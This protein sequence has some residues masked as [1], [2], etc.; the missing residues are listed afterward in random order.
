MTQVGRSIRRL[1]DPRLVTG[2]GHFVDDLDRAG[3]VHA[4]FVRASVAHAVLRGVEVSDALALDGVRAVISATDVDLPRIPLRVSPMVEGLEAYL[5]P[6]LATGR[7]RYVGEPIA[8]VVADDPYAAEDA[9]ELVEVDFEVLPCNLDPERS[10]GGEASELFEGRPN[11]VATLRASFGDVE[12]ALG[13]AA[14]VIEIEVSIGRQ[15]AVPI[16]PRGLLA[17]WDATTGSLEIWGA[18]KVPHFNRRVIAAALGLDE[19]RVRLHAGDAGGGFGVRGE[20]Y[21]EDLIVAW[22]A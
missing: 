8:V 21:P 14:H 22:L 17:E 19:D 20:L 9:A 3:Q 5:Q 6:A 4:R 16:E 15:T 7:L 12:A 1:E 11:E 13:R 2:R 18:T 10:A